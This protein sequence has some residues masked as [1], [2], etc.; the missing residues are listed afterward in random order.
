MT[1]DLSLD[2]HTGA[3]TL[4][5]DW[6]GA[7]AGS[8]T[9]SVFHRT[10]WLRAVERGTDLM[11][12]HVV[13]SRGG[14]TVG[15]CPNF[16]SDVPLPVEVPDSMAGFAPRELVSTEPGFGGPVVAGDHR[17]VLDRLLDG[18]RAAATDDVWAHRLRALDPG[19]VSYADHLD[20]RGYDAA[21]LTCQLAIDLSRS[22]DAI[23]DDWSKD[24]RREARKAREAGTTVT[25]VDPVADPAALDGFYDAYAAMIDRVDGVRYSRAFVDA[26]ADELGDRLVLLRADLDDEP[27]GWHLYLRDDERESLHH[28]FSGL[29]AEHFGHHPSSRI[30]EYAVEWAISEGFEEYNFGESNAD[31]TDGGFAYKS[32]YGG[33][34]S[35]VLT[36][37]RGIAPAR[38]TAFRAARRL[39]RT[40]QGRQRRAADETA[41]RRAAGTADRRT[42]DGTATGSSAESR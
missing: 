10:G 19:A 12:R 37:E 20:S 11:P 32:Q 8:A 34:V 42:P 38:W 21:V 4:P 26:L 23:L 28:F 31:V 30:H 25:H 3:A 33:S 2:V 24:R 1:A 14:S 22:V 36:W 5:R 15:L 16:V 35:P 39:Y 40:V 9:G 17:R 7:V 41:G 18:V 29:R 6:D 13:V 27:V